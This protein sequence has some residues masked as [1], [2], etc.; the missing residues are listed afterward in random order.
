[1]LYGPMPAD[2]TSIRSTVTASSVRFSTL[3]LTTIGTEVAVRGCAELT[4]SRAMPMVGSAGFFAGA[5]DA[6][7]V[8]VVESDDGDDAHAAQVR[9]KTHTRYRRKV[10]MIGGW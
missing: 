7:V 6:P 10:F 8:L 4:S 5:V 2:A 1:M 9:Q 3:T